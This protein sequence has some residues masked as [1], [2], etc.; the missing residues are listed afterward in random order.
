MAELDL[1]E[2]L[3]RGLKVHPRVA[4]QNLFS[5]PGAVQK[6]AAA[7]PIF[8]PFKGKSYKA[9]MWILD[10]DHRVPSRDF[11]LRLYA[12]YSLQGKAIG[13]L[14]YADRDAHTKGRGI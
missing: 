7:L 9:A 4:S 3:K 12:F 10:W 5:E 1:R 2:E 11:V 13:E 14:S 8:L 6:M